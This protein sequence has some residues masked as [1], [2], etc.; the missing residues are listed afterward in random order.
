MLIYKWDNLEN[1]Q[2]LRVESKT[3]NLINQQINEVLDIF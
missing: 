3:K 1:W 2:L